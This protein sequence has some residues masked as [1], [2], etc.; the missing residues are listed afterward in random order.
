M[1]FFFLKLTVNK[2]GS[3][4]IFS[5]AIVLQTASCCGYIN[6][7][8]RSQFC[9]L[10]WDSFAL[11]TNWDS[12]DL[13]AGRLDH[14][15]RLPLNQAPF[16][17]RKTDKWTAR[18]QNGGSR[19]RGSDR[20]RSLPPPLLPS[21]S[22]SLLQLLG[23]RVAVISLFL[24]SSHQQS[25]P[26]PLMFTQQMTN[27]RTRGPTCMCACERAHN[28]RCRQWLTCCRAILTH[29]VC[30]WVQTIFFFFLNVLFCVC[31]LQNLLKITCCPAVW[32]ELFLKA[33]FSQFF[34]FFMALCCFS[35][36]KKVRLI[37][38]F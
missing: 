17:C 21:P 2:A 10:N 22:S 4:S 30:M 7:L 25:A 37:A 34:P 23:L 31:A 12:C 16:C 24:H 9:I 26:D 33:F 3:S 27:G 6:K 20:R 13:A 8:R 19:P 36:F 11:V 32:P 15:G 1:I 14:V 38:A 29:F 18:G 28:Y 35:I 5:D